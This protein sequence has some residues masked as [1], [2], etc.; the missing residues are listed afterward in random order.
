MAE[1]REKKT[2]ASASREAV[3]DE[4]E[5]R[6]DDTQTYPRE[7]LVEGGL[8]DYPPHVVAGALAGA[9]ATPKNLSIEETNAA[10]KAWL[11]SPVQTPEEA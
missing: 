3:K 6:D 7:M 10:C 8:T 2:A 5:E 4:R 11:K 1:D 9:G